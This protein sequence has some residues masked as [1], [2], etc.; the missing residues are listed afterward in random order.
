MSRRGVLVALVAL[1]AIQ[2]AL[3]YISASSI[4]APTTDSGSVGAYVAIGLATFIVA[5]GIGVAAR[6]WQGAIVF[7]ALAWWAAV[8]AHAGHLLRPAPGVPAGYVP[9]WLIPNLILDLL[10]SLAL[11]AA[12]AWV[13]WLAGRALRGELARH[14]IPGQP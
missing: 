9:Y 8:L 6:T 10:A 3:L 12:L 11:F 14:T 7:A 4:L 13:G 5:P 2:A 1:V